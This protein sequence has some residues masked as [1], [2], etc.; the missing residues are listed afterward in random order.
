MNK[1]S[2][3]FGRNVVYPNPD[4]AVDIQYQLNRWLESED[5]DVRAELDVR[6]VLVA[7]L[8]ARSTVVQDTT[9]V[10]MM[11]VDPD[12]IITLVPLHGEGMNS[13]NSL[14][15]DKQHGCCTRGG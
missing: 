10:H 2:D 14:E 3:S 8:L 15:F 1:V 4:D 11:P 9:V 13:S 5:H 12:D 6:P 7:G